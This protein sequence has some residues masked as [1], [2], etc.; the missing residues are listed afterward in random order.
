M[1]EFVR[2]PCTSS[3]VSPRRVRWYA[4]GWPATKTFC[5][6]TVPRGG[7]VRGDST[8]ANP[9]RKGRTTARHLQPPSPCP[10]SPS[11]L[12][13]HP[14]GRNHL[15]APRRRRDA[16]RRPWALR[17]RRLEPGG[18][19]V[20]AA[21]GRPVRPPR[22]AG[23]VAPPVRVPAAPARRSGGAARGRAARPGLRRLPR[24]RVAAGDA[25]RAG[26]RRR[27][28]AALAALDPGPR[29]PVPEGPR[30]P[31]RDRR[32]AGLPLAASRHEARARDPLLGGAVHP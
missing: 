17:L 3:T 1:T 8:V 18:A 20:G 12:T 30:R 10:R 22:R 31:R 16:G 32:G 5:V 7:A 27:V 14:H 25:L 9:P 19:A 21:A 28:A 2:V 6:S 11:S 26:L 24:P 29:L 23:G 4:I 13:S 15:G